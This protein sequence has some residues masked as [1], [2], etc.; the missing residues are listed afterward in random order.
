MENLPQKSI[1]FVSNLPHS[2][3]NNPRQIVR[4]KLRAFTL[5]ETLMTSVIAII[6]IAFLT[7][8][9]LNT[10]IG[11]Q[12][13]ILRQELNYNLEYTIRQLSYHLKQTTVVNEGNSTFASHPGRI[14]V[15]T[16]ESSFNPLIISSN[17]TDLLLERGTEGPFS[18]ISSRNT[19]SNF[20]LTFQTPNNSTGSITGNLTLQS[21][22]DP[23]VS[24]SEDFSITL[25]NNLP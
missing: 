16:S 25:R 7:S 1:A 4:A 9:F 20:S 13:F 22:I 21:A 11:K 8:F 14:E 24:V 15:T 2:M 6:I 23:D 3:K 17:G 19:V 10:I 5:V 18:L 12:L